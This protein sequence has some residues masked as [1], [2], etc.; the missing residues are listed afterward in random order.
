MARKT[1]VA[2]FLSPEERKILE[3]WQRSTTMRAGLVK[4]GRI[5]L[6][7]SEGVP[8]SHIARIVGM[9]RRFVYKWAERFQKHRLSGLEDKAGRGREPFFPCAGSDSLGQDS[10]RKTYLRG[11]IPITMGFNGAGEKTR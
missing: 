7:L 9:R 4:R 3:A 10:L 2:V 8:I 11:K 6:L 5:I 1:S